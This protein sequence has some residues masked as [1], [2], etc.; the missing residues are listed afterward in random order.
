MLPC[1]DHGG[2]WKSRVVPL[3][4]NDSQDNSLCVAPVQTA[5]GQWIAKCMEMIEVD[6]VARIIT[7]YMQ[8]LQYEPKK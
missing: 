7:R 6:D 3:K 1:C 4:D 8:N 2:C 5:D